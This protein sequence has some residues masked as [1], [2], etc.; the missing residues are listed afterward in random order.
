VCKGCPFWRLWRSL[1]TLVF[2]YLNE[3]TRSSP[4]LFEIK[5]NFVSNLTAAETA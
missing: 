3:M 5:N 4:A 1:L 2:F